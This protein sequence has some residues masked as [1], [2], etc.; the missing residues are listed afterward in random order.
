MASSSPQLR[1]RFSLDGT[2][3]RARLYMAAVGYGE[4]YVNGERVN[5]GHLDPAWTDYEERVLYTTHDITANLQEGENVVGFWLGRD[6]FS[7]RHAYWA[8]D[9]SPRVRATLFIEFDDG[10][11]QIFSTDENWS[12]ATSPIIANDIYNGER[13]D[14]RHERPQ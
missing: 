8:S 10:T 6:W 14:A 9:G 12:A 7:K 4:A 3:A 11:T 13:Y 1:N 5:D 2:V